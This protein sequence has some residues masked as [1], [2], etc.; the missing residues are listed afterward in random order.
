MSSGGGAFLDLSP[1]ADVVGEKV[2]S[3]DGISRKSGWRASCIDDTTAFATVSAIVCS[4]GFECSPWC[5]SV[6]SSVR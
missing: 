6:S 3:A 2:A 5:E 4:S 1:M